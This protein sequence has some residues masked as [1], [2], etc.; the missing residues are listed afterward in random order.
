MGQVWPR[1]GKEEQMPQKIYK[2]E[3]IEVTYDPGRCTHAAECVRG[4]PRVFNTRKRP[5]VN[6]DGASADRVAEIIL[7]CPTGAL[8]YERVDGG[9]N[10]SP[11]P[12][13]QVTL[14][15]N[16]P[17]YLRG[18]IWILNPDGSLFMEDTRMALCRCGHSRNKPFCDNSHV[19]VNF[20]ANGAVKMD[21]DSR[22]G[23]NPVGKLLV[24]PTV[25][26][27]YLLEGN[28]ELVTWRGDVLFQG[29]EVTLCR[30]GSSANKPFCDGSHRKTH[31]E[32]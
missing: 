21:V 2:G 4:L 19:R 16:G 24:T 26:G 7:K 17:L 29:T 22:E 30:C 6:L 31:F 15:P 20:D 11:G 12:R 10:E 1:R 14:I 32:G 8:H 3:G 5:W 27:P 9:E 18:E 28:F 23:F 25:N 13:N